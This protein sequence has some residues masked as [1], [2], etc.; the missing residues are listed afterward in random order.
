MH[1]WFPLGYNGQDIANGRD[2]LKALYIMQIFLFHDIIY[3]YCVIA[4]IQPTISVLEIIKYVNPSIHRVVLCSILGH[5]STISRLKMNNSQVRNPAMPLLMGTWINY[6]TFCYHGYHNYK[7]CYIVVPPFIA[8]T[9]FK[10][11]LLAKFRE[12]GNL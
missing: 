12:A 10:K 7:M 9:K 11:L 1:F 2:D 5:T 6:P 3:S 4:N 8:A